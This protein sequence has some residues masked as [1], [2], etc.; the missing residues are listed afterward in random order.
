MQLKTKHKILRKV[1]EHHRKKNKAMKHKLAG[2]SKKPKKLM[3]PSIPS[4]WPFKEQVM[5]EYEAI[6]AKE[7]AVEAQKKAERKERKVW[8][9]YATGFELGCQKCCW[10][11]PT[12]P[13]KQSIFVTDLLPKTCFASLQ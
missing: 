11:E 7:E 12:T 10:S 5:Q 4:G 8:E 9:T 13:T 6:K 3:A 1:K 2:A